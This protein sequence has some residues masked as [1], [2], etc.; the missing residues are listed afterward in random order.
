MKVCCIRNDLSDWQIIGGLV[1]AP[2]PRLISCLV[3]L[4]D[5]AFGDENVVVDT[6]NSLQMQRM[7]LEGICCGSVARVED[8]EGLLKSTFVFLHVSL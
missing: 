4:D 5:A 3:P 6:K 2:L 8:V 7:L 1:T